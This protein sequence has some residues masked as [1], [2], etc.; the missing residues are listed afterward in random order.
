MAIHTANI[1]EMGYGLRLSVSQGGQS[2]VSLSLS[3][4]ISFSQCFPQVR[5]WNP[6]GS[7]NWSKAAKKDSRQ[8]DSVGQ[9]GSKARGNLHL[10]PPPPHCCCRE[11]FPQ[12]ERL[13]IK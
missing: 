10:A 7:P 5:F 12:E 2:F 11:V 9:V 3:L 6:S 1:V 13:R 8:E 4:C